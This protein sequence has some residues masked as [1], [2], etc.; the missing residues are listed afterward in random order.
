MFRTLRAI[1]SQHRRLNDVETTSQAHAHDVKRLEQTLREL[2]SDVEW[3]AGEVRTLRGKVT[4]GL[5]KKEPPAEDDG[6]PPPQQDV[7]AAIKTGT[8]VR[9][10]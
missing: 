10:R 5:R 6:G 9:R 3:L 8:F 7:N 2:A 4:G 1:L